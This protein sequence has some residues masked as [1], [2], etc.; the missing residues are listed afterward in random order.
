[1]RPER[2]VANAAGARIELTPE[3]VA[4]IDGLSDVATR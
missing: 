3:E 4:A 1:V 2:I